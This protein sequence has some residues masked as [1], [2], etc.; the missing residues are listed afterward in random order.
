MEHHQQ[1]HTS[2]CHFSPSLCQ[3]SAA[4]LFKLPKLN[5]IFGETQSFRVSAIN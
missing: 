4:Y 1:M 5:A 3:Y 2:R